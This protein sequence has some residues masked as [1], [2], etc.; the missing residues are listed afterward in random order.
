M[1]DRVSGVG[2]LDKS[3][4]ILVAVEE[5]AGTMAEVMARTGIP[6]PTAHR[7]ATALEAHGLLR[8]DGAGVVR[9]G[10]RLVALGHRAGRG[11]PWLDSAR[12]VLADLRALTG[13]SV[14]L[15]VGDGDARL[16]VESLESAEELRTTVP[17]GSRLPLDRGSAGRV[18]SGDGGGR[19]GWVESVEERA[20]GVASVSAPVR[21]G[22][23]AVAVS[24]S[25]PVE[26]TSRSPGRRFGADVVRAARRIEALAAGPA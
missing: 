22:A 6:R 19:R 16:C 9:L 5:G 10:T 8:R 26:R 13:E 11:W 3:M 24:V 7:L 23:E 4:A 15:Y 25:G 21:I 20:P 14:Q 2:V 18:L 17:V 1:S 12:P